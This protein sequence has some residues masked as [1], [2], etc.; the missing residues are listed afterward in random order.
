ML[1]ASPEVPLDLNGR[2]VALCSQTDT[3]LLDFL[4][5]FKPFFLLEAFVLSQAR[6]GPHWTQEQGG[7]LSSTAQEPAGGAPSPGLLKGF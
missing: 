7:H 5:I 6:V 2:V 3:W 1:S 4:P